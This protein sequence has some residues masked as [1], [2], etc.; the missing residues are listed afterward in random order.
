MDNKEIF[1]KAIGSLLYLAT[2][3]RLDIAVSTSI[4]SRKVVNPTQA[5]WTK[6]KRVLDI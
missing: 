2:N 1:R 5:D 4:L 3:T 6:I